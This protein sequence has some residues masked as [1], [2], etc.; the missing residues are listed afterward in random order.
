MLTWL[1][2]G[3]FALAASAVMLTLLLGPARQG[4]RRARLVILTLVWLLP[5]QLAMTAAA[6][7]RLLRLGWPDPWWPIA[8]WAVLVFWAGLVRLALDDWSKTAGAGAGPALARLLR[9]HLWL[10]YVP[11]VLLLP[12]Y[13]AWAWA[14]DTA[15]GRLWA[16]PAGHEGG[17]LVAMGALY[18]GTAVWL[19]GPPASVSPA[20][21]VWR[22]GLLTIVVLFLCSEGLLPL[23]PNQTLPGWLIQVTATLPHALMVLTSAG[24]IATDGL[25]HPTLAAG[26]VRGVTVVTAGIVGVLG[27]GAVEPFVPDRWSTTLAAFT[28]VVLFTATMGALR[29]WPGGFEAVTPQ[30]GRQG[31]LGEARQAP[32]EEARPG[33]QADAGPA[34]PPAWSAG[35]PVAD[36]N[37][38]PG[39]ELLTPRQREVV[40]AALEG[41]SNA[42]IA[43][44]LCIAEVTVKK[45]LSAAFQKLG[46][47]SRAQLIASLTREA[48][49]HGAL[50]AAAPHRPGGFTREEQAL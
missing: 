9:R 8:D 18:V 46:V 25:V 49:M 1:L 20:A 12:V 42:E 23:L 5:T 44:R 38:A 48:A 47:S 50:Q 4:H 2:Y 13:L 15:L 24:A 41:L 36:R 28:G 22:R 26:I 3:G 11:P 21:R 7:N 40:L 32:Q 33:P 43:E 29:T 30:A 37:P 14:P 17:V 19:W 6:L 27:G 35:A 16:G 45:H 39:L 34:P 10:P 31:R